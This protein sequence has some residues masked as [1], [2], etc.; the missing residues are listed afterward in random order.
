MSN[1]AAG[2]DTDDEGEVLNDVEKTLNSL[3]IALR[4]SKGEWRSFEDVLDEVAAKWKSFSDTERS[5][6]ATAI[7]GTRQQENFRAMMNNWSEVDRLVNVAANSTGSASERME[8]YLDSIEAKTN[9][10]KASWENFVMSLNQ[11]ESWGEV[12]DILSNLLDKLIYVDWEKVIATIS[13]FTALMI[14]IKGAKSILNI[15]QAGGGIASLVAGLSG[16]IPVLLGI[17][18]ALTTVYVAWDSINKNSKKG[19]EDSK[20]KVKQLEEE[21]STVDDLLENYKSLSAKSRTVGLTENEKNELKSISEQLVNQYG[22]E[23]EAIDSLTGAYIIGEDAIKSYYD[24][25][26]KELEKSK[27]ERDK[28]FNEYAKDIN[29]DLS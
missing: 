11:S 27:A 19:F 2:K 10:L 22:L 8:V 1:V 14:A 29:K 18:A 26:N 3:N 7:A 4:S 23:Y 5:H 24:T 9:K 13:A 28:A 20:T 25:A 12:L 17:A 16:I 21:K 15:I 6:I